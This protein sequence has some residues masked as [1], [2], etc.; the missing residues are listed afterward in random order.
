MLNKNY[1][2]NYICEVNYPSTSAYALHVIKMCDSL[3]ADN[4][5]INLIAPKISCNF[6]KLKKIY[7]LK[8]KFKLISIFNK[9]INIFFFS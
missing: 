1:Q 5:N 7:N 4:T 3:S 6:L 2:I 9:K 8:N